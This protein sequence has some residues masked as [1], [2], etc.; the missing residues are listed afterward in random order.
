M[1]LGAARRVG[2][3]VAANLAGA[4]LLLALLEGIARG[5]APAEPPALFD[6]PELH[7]RGRPFVV[8]HPQRGF[9]LRPGFASEEIRVG[10]WGLRGP[11]RS[12]PFAGPL[13]LAVGD[14]T[15]FGWGVRDD[16]AWPAVLERRLPGVTVLNAGVP[17]YTSPQA[18]AY[19]DELLPRFSPDIVLIGV[20][21]N[22][23]WFSSLDPWYPEALVLRRPRAWRRWLFEHSALFR[24]LAL[25]G[26]PRAARQDVFNTRALD[27]YASQLDAMAR[28]CARAGARLVFLAP[29][30][31]ESHLRE[32]GGT[33]LGQLHF[34]RPFVGELARR[35]TAALAE[36]A[37]RHGVAA[38]DHRISLSTPRQPRLF[39]DAI[40]AT[41]EGH[42]LLAGDVAR[43]LRQQGWLESP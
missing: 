19:L 30:F 13:L 9:A 4:A 33:P 23:I 35:Y 7:R 5:L 39:L 42:R 38:L 18:R 27:H 2:L 26:R 29:P 12:P 32:D 10:A 6:L 31:D 37:S 22:D 15:V 43:F 24:A 8:A 36:V 11:E 41:A 14:S 25:R 28:A 16:E 40:H 20:L 34:S 21:W 17:S 3:V 1:G